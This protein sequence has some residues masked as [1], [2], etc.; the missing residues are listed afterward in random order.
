LLVLSAAKMVEVIKRSSNTDTF[1]D[2]F[3]ST[4][5]MTTGSLDFYFELKQAIGLKQLE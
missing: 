2:L 5:H 4:R 3:M 1:Y